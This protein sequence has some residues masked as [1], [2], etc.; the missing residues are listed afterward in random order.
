MS[1]DLKH[2]CI[3]FEDGTYDHIHVEDLE[4]VFE[5]AKRWAPEDP[6][7]GIYLNVWQKDEE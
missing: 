1:I 3:E 6:I 2:Y 7:L 4:E 5:W